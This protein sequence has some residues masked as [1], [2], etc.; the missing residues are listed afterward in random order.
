MGYKKRNKRFLLI[1]ET[2][3]YPISLPSKDHLSSIAKKDIGT[4]HPFGDVYLSRGT[5]EDNN[6]RMVFITAK[7]P[8]GHISGFIFNKKDWLAENNPF[9]KIKIKESSLLLKYAKRIRDE[10]QSLKTLLKGG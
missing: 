9:S 3:H 2:P 7:Q 1:N 8:N 4:I 6:V 5:H 10:M